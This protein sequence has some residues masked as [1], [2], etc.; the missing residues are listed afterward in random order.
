MIDKEASEEF[1]KIHGD[2]TCDFDSNKAIR[3]VIY[4]SFIPTLILRS[5][6]A[7]KYH[8]KD[9][10]DFK[11]FYNRTEIYWHASYGGWTLTNLLFYMHISQNCRDMFVMSMINF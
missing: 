6:G 3:A 4:W 9:P 10:L 1:R 2:G 7:Y 5:I 11:T 8:N